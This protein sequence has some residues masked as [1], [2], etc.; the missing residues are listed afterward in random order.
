MPTEPFR[1]L[2]DRD[3]SKV[4]SKEIIDICSP[5]LIEVINYCTWA[6]QRC[7]RFAKSGENIDLPALLQ[8]RHIIELTD[9]IETL[10]SN[11]C[12]WTTIPLLRALFESCMYLEY[13]FK[14]N[15]NQKALAWLLVY[16]YNRKEV[17]ERLDADTP[18]G[19]QFKEA[20]Q[21]QF[22]DTFPTDKLD[23]PKIAEIENVNA[24]LSRKMYK[25]IIEEY[26][27]TKKKKRR[28]PEWFELFGGPSNRRMLCVDLGRTAEYD[29]LY[30]SWSS[31][32]HGIDL[33]QY[34]TGT[35]G[36]NAAFWAIR[37]PDS[38]SDFTS[39]AVTFLIRS[40]MCMMAKYRPQED[41]AKWYIRE[42]KPLLDRL[43]NTKIT[44]R[45]IDDS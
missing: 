15:Y 42:V 29:F 39:L 12:S 30:K 11:S 36:G 26:L 1:K 14:D 9:G 25:P 38:M 45:G 35:A 5:L 4:D 37:S 13:L 8:F 22:G 23:I 2:L 16:L 17:Y 6:F 24:E 19:E 32:S 10:V 7:N 44:I 41:I 27:R 18:K 20:V 31:V 3:Y 43:R 34:F 28:K 40:L 33:N 21:N